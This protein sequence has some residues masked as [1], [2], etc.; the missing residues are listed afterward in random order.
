[1]KWELLE[2]DRE[3]ALPPWAEGQRHDGVV[4]GWQ[5]ATPWFWA[6]MCQLPGG[7]RGR[8]QSRTSHRGGKWFING[9]CGPKEPKSPNKINKQSIQLLIA[10]CRKLNPKGDRPHFGENQ[11]RSRKRWR[12]LSRRPEAVHSVV[13]KLSHKCVFTIDLTYLP[14]C[15]G[16]TC[17]LH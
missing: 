15:T 10:H 7:T 3:W 12:I 1:M 6:T 8:R 2:K 9:K 17:Y 16:N 5:L 4:Q 13:V 14:F 11:L